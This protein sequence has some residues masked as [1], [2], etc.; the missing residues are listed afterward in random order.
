MVCEGHK[1]SVVYLTTL[2]NNA[3]FV[4]VILHILFRY[5]EKDPL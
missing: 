4:T 5:K 1:G 3:Y 2:L